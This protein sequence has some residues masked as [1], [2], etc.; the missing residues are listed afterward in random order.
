MKRRTVSQTGGST[1]HTWYDLFSRGAR[2]WLRHNQKVR[3]AVQA[4][5]PDLIAGPDLITGPQDRTVQVPVRLLEHA[6]FRLADTRSASGAGQGEGQ[7]GDVL[8]PAQAH[9]GS[10][11][12]QDEDG[13]GNQDGEVR[14]LLEFSIDD[15]M[16]WLWDELKLPLLKPKHNTVIDEHELVRE[17]WDKRGAR[18]R[19]DRR[20]TVKEAIKRRAM[21]D[22]P[23]AFTNEDLRFRQLVMRPK[24]SSNAVVFFVVDVSAS[25]T[26]AER[27]L[28]KSF[29]FFA[30]QGIRRSYAKVETRFIAHTTRAWEFSENEFFQVT[31]IG[32]TIASSAF[33][34]TRELMRGKYDGGQYNAY[35]FYA[36]D[37]E[38]FTEDR[39]AAG[40]ALAELAGVLNY[41][42]YVETVP[43][44]PRSL[45]T[46]M[47]RLCNELSHRGLPIYSSVL[48]NSDDVWRAIRKFFVHQIEP[49]DGKP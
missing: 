46:E 47:R 49:E 10:E 32:G 45:E 48:A 18:S 15:I 3:E 24:P 44:M 42:G 25:M 29:F 8:R 7:P 13:G 35:M 34:L 19:L 43:G 9:P 41:T 39:A 38:N 12:G 33:R 20:R 31:G 11:P 16:D 28:A 23:V 2:D 14:L 26:Q 22:N 6:R 5:L 37:G 17:G 30:L 40:A 4:H 36:S 1:Q 27:K 21:Q